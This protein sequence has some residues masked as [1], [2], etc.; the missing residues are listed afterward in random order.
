MDDNER[1]LELSRR[2]MHKYIIRRNV[3]VACSGCKKPSV[4]SNKTVVYYCH[5]CGTRNDAKEAT[6]RFD[7]GEYDYEDKCGNFATPAFKTSDPNSREYM[8]F[9]DEYEIRAELFS[10]GITRDS[11]GIDKFHKTLKKELKANKCYRGPEA[12][13]V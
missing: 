7:N 4:V 2:S 3:A 11:V 5:N 6:E 10:K 1:A 8:K 12:T 13:G 9:R